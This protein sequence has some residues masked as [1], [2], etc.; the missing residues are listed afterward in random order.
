MAGKWFI[1]DPLDPSQSS[2]NLPLNAKGDL[3]TFQYL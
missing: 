3:S 2:P 1:L